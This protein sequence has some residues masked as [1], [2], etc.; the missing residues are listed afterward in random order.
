MQISHL[1]EE[2]LYSVK[3]VNIRGKSLQTPV[4]S[5]NFRNLR[6][7]IKIGHREFMGEIYKT[8]DKDKIRGLI[9]DVELQ[10]NFNRNLNS[11][12]RI[13]EHFEIENTL[14]I[15][16]LA[17]LNPDENELRFIIAT[18][19]QYS[20]FYVVPTVERLSK[21]MKEGCSIGDYHALVKEY[22]ALLEGYPEKPV[23]GMI[24]ISIPYQYIG[25]LMKLY[26]EKG[27]ESFCVDVGGR[28]ALSLTQQVTEVQRSLK[29]NKVEAFIHATNVNIG[30]AKKKSNVIT[31]K[32]LL[33]FGMGFDSIGDNHIGGGR[34]D[35]PPVPNL[36]LFDKEGYGYHKIH[37]LGEIGEV[38]PEDSSVHPEHFLDESLSRRKK[39]QSMFNYEQIGIETGRLAR[40]IGEGEV[41][42]YLK[43]KAYV[44]DSSFKMIV[45]VRRDMAQTRLSYEDYLR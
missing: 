32:D 43:S 9:E 6:K 22:L 23:M 34:K 7:D 13:G 27:I 3:R 38:Y 36:R 41:G 14:F 15:P 24:P 28:V 35:T 40:I 45:K 20:E 21:R 10:V 19:K 17:Y 31:A 44:D 5:V 2:T 18:Q 26:L 16:A 1:D 30:R 25:D 37:D 29:E 39:A 11:S 8:F 33:S 42:E 12:I 4:K